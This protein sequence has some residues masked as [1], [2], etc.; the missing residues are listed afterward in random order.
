MSENQPKRLKLDDRQCR[1]ILKDLKEFGYESLTF[2]E[3]RKIADQIA[4]GTHNTS[5]VIAVMI[6]RQIDEVMAMLAARKAV[7][8]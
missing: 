4:D 5:E 1:I 6:C 3:V 8:K 2:D 7:R